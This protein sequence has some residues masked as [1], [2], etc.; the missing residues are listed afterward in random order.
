MRKLLH[1]EILRL[2]LNQE[3]LPYVSRNPIY[4]M[5]YNIRSLYNVGSIFRTADAA[6]VSELI[7]TGFT[8]YPP[9]KEIE[10]T[11]LG[12]DKTVP[13]R[14]FKEHNDAIA[15]L[16][17]RRIKIFAL[18]ITDTGKPYYSIS[19]DEFPLCIILGNELTGI[20]NDILA[21]CD[22]SIEIPMYGVK[23][24]LNV[25]VAAGIAAFEAIKIWH[26]NNNTQI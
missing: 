7:L 22:D 4:L 5:L 18:E 17:E 2:R 13:W 3:Q 15:Y 14:Y 10:K 21:L 12:A 26:I 23:H 25:S 6:L 1:S 8:P 16:K 20:D 24:S 9:R 11:A 19:A